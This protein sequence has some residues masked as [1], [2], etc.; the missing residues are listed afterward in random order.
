MPQNCLQFGSW[1]HSFYSYRPS[2]TLFFRI[3]MFPRRL[4]KSCP[5]RLVFIL[6]L[7]LNYFCPFGYFHS[8][9]LMWYPK[10]NQ[11]TCVPGSMMI[12]ACFSTCHSPKKFWVSISFYCIHL[13]I[14][15]LL[16]TYIYF[17]MY[18]LSLYSSILLLWLDWISFN[19]PVIMRVV[20]W[21]G[22]THY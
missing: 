17:P 11:R 9:E 18:S 15:S 14:S 4:L 13:S 7:L 20:T 22:D 3:Y 10:L 19:F 16:F 12:S 6:Q 2:I 8:I 1:I 5:R 21:A